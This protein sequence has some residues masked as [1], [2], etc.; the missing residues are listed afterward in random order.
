[1]D[2]DCRASYAIPMRQ[3]KLGRDVRIG[4]VKEPPHL[5]EKHYKRYA[6]IW[7]R[8]ASVS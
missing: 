2:G 1:M 3:R 5:Y 6:Q 4:W 7:S 8:T